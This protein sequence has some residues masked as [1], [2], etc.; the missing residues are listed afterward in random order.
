MAVEGRGHI[1]FADDD[2]MVLRATASA[3]SFSGFEVTA[4]EDGARVLSSLEQRAPDV[5]LL[6][7]N[8]PGN[9]NLDLVDGL[10]RTQPLIPI[11]ILTG[12]PALD[13]AMRAVRLGVVDYLFKPYDMG[14]LI[15]RLDLAVHRARKLRCDWIAAR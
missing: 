6:D 8:M 9:Q 15:E 13:T 11:M 3:L 10:S 1:L 2:A 5:L 12:Y 7:I 4:V 14:H